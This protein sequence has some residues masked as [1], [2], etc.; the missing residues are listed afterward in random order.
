MS[1]IQTIVQSDVVVAGFP[2][3][4]KKQSS[5]AAKKAKAAAQLKNAKLAKQEVA[6]FGEIKSDFSTQKH[7]TKLLSN[8]LLSP[9]YFTK[10]ASLQTVVKSNDKISNRELRAQRRRNVTSSDDEMIIA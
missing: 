2:N 6:E 4:I 7:K 5:K 3:L 1:A 9:G 8:S 10:V